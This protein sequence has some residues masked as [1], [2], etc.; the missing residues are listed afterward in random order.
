MNSVGEHNESSEE[1]ASVTDKESQTEP[2]KEE[3][4]SHYCHK[5]HGPKHII[6]P[7]PGRC[8]FYVQRKK[9]FCKMMLKP[10]H[11]YCGE[12]TPLPVT[13]HEI[14]S[15]PISELRV[16]C[17]YDPKHTVFASKMERHLK[18]CNSKP[19]AVQP[20]YFKAG[21]NSGDRGSPPD[22]KDSKDTLTIANVSD[23]KLINII[24]MLMATYKK[25]CE[26]EIPMEPLE[27]SVIEE[28]LNKPEY[29]PSVLK[30]L[31]Q[32]SSMIGH[33]DKS[34]LLENG[35]TFV[36]FGSG[37]GQLTYW[38][39]KAVS[40]H[41]TCQFIL[42]DKA[43]HRHKFDNRLRD[44]EDLDLV[45]L[46]IDIQDLYLGNVAPQI[47]Q[48]KENIIGVSKHLCGAATDLAL[49]CLTQTLEGVDSCLGGI[50]IALCC[51]HRCSWQ[52][53]VGKEFLTEQ[54][55]TEEDFSLLTTLTSWCTCGS[56][57][58]RQKDLPKLSPA[59]EKEESMVEDAVLQNGHQSPVSVSPVEADHEVV[60][61]EEQEGN[62][63]VV[64]NKD[65][66][67]RLQLDQAT[68]EEIGR[69]CKR[70][71]DWG[72][73]RYLEDNTDLDVKFKYYVDP[74]IS[75]ENSMLLCT[76]PGP[77]ATG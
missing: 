19:L 37:R 20:D 3:S 18:I 69:Q 26:G 49:R 6:R 42:V 54:G 12:H 11:Q 28:E 64:S 66:Y 53:Y 45:R 31:I 62:K 23:E 41:S 55:F 73:L 63:E 57:L 58:P 44:E 13:E 43:S 75:L 27:H 74:F 40:D 68:R 7:E 1:M 72:R 61:V 5:E 39:T 59:P 22:A 46:R 47:T 76:K 8:G 65:R 77:M 16:P 70:V 17:P 71:L 33:M 29:G 25:F 14:G 38:L 48:Q 21:I 32:N 30:H 51:H 67:T 56:G 34:G 10:G 4:E 50:L 35:N 36:E 15:K 24:G 9:R 52:T 2:F 60:V